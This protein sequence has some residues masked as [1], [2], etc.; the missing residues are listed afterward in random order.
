MGEQ[1][2]NVFNINESFYENMKKAV[3]AAD[4]LKKQ[5]ISVKKAINEI[6]KLEI[7]LKTNSFEKQIISVK[8]ATKEISEVE[9]KLKTNSFEKQIISVKK[10]TKEISEVEIKLKT[11]SFE[12]Q[13]I[14]IKKAIKEISEVEIKLKEEALKKSD[15]PKEDN[16]SKI[17]NTMTDY[18]NTS[19][20]A[21]DAYSIYKAINKKFPNNPI[22]K[23]FSRIGKNISRAINTI[24]STIRGANIG[25]TVKEAF[26]GIPNILKNMQLGKTLKGA[27]DEMPSIF[28]SI[29]KEMPNTLKLAFAPIGAVFIGL[30]RII[31]RFAIGAIEALMGLN[32]MLLLL[33]VGVGLF[34]V[35]WKSNFRGIR[36]DIE[37]DIKEIGE[38]LDYLYNHF[39]EVWNDTLKKLGHLARHPIDSIMEL[40][41]EG[42][43]FEKNPADKCAVGTSYFHGG[44]SWVG[45]QG[46]ELMKLPGGTQILDNRTSQNMLGGSISVEKLADTLVVREDSDIDRIADALAKKLTKVGFN[47]V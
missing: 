43:R 44:W 32:P 5:I 15:K 2:R 17:R 37:K 38:R 6:S 20:I 46:P 40:R 34:A 24:K 47:C 33:I 42:S 12:K 10:A 23:S 9:I 7:K 35:A 41:N 36:D 45:E 22:A 19:T 21:K 28:K 4:S 11:D 29:S 14:S 3:N 26:G 31:S 18:V 1:N 39:N 25:K 30:G 13:I 16:A 8:K 27:F